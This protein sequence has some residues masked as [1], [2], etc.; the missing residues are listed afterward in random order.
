MLIS[1]C[2]PRRGV[3]ARAE[4][5]RSYLPLVTEASTAYK[6]VQSS[7]YLSVPSLLI[8]GLIYLVINFVLSRLVN[9]LEK[10]LRASDR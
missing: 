3:Q 7:T 8:S 1:I 4:I 5:A 2:S 9:L 6:T 10:R